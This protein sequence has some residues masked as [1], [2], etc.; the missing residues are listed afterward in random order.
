MTTKDGLLIFPRSATLKNRPVAVS[1]ATAAT[2]TPWVDLGAALRESKAQ[3]QIDGS[4]VPFSTM[5]TDVYTNLQAIY[6]SQRPNEGPEANM[7]FNNFN[8]DPDKGH[9]PNFQHLIDGGMVYGGWVRVDYGNLKVHLF[10]LPEGHDSTADDSAETYVD[11]IVGETITV[12]YDHPSYFQSFFGPGILEPPQ[13]NIVEAAI[14]RVGLPQ[15]GDL[16]NLT[17]GTS[18]IPAE[19]M[20]LNIYE[21]GRNQGFGATNE[22]APIFAPIRPDVTV[23]ID[24]ETTA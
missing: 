23:T 7:A 16:S 21:L 9:P 11:N 20:L 5:A 2:A 4:G 1:W 6:R 10:T 19:S 13:N 18:G 24:T 22:H 14:G 12:G 17:I 3:S 8:F 15:L